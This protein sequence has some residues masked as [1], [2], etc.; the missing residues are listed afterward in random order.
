MRALGGRE[1]SDRL[2]PAGGT[3][4]HPGRP[5]RP[6][7]RPAR[8]LRSDTAVVP[9]ARSALPRG[10][11]RCGDVPGHRPVGRY[12]SRAAARERP[13]RR[14]DPHARA[15]RLVAGRDAA[16][17]RACRSADHRDRGAA[18]RRHRRVSRRARFH[19]LGTR[20]R[21][22]DPRLRGRRGGRSRDGERRRDRGLAQGAHDAHVESARVDDDAG[23]ARARAGHAA[24][25]DQHGRPGLGRG[26]AASPHVDGLCPCRRPRAANGAELG[27]PK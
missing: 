10:R 4:H 6:R 25:D 14:A 16:R 2:V 18:S 8:D 17:R 22:L 3:E 11:S 20:V 5:E 13:R 9:P 12:A 21:G 1:R 24:V 23:H 27:W 7:H 26:R 15:S 19:P